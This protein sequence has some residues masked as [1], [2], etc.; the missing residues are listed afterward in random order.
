M[1][2][3][4]IE[5]D[6][7]KGNPPLQLTDLVQQASLHI[8][9]N[10]FA[11][12]LDQL[13]HNI[14]ESGYHDKFRSYVDK[15]AS[16]DQN[17]KFWRQIV[18]KDAL[19]YIGLFL[20]IRSGNWELRLASIKLMA[21]VFTAFDHQTYRKLIAQH[22]AD[23][24]SFPDEVLSTFRQGGFV[25]SLTGRS[26]HSVAL[27]EAHEMKINKECKTSIVHPSRDYINRVAGYIPYR[28]KC[29]E[30][31]RHQ[32]FPVETNATSLAT[33][34][35]STDAQTKKSAANIEAQ[36]QLM[37]STGF[38][39]NLCT[40]HE[41]VN[42]FVMKY[43]TPEQQHDLLHFRNIGQDEFERHVSYYILKEASVHPPMR[44]K[45]L[46]TL[47]QRKVTRRQLSQLE[48]DRQM[49][50][51]CLH[52]KIKWSKQTG[53]PIDKIAEQYIP[54]PLALADSNGIPL[55]GQKSNT[56][57]ALKMRYKDAIPQVFLNTLPEQW[58][59]GC[60][61][62]EGMFM[63]N[64][65]PLGS[66]KTFA[67]YANFLIKRFV[68]PHY[69]K[70]TKDVHMIF[71]NPGRLSQTPKYFERK[72]RDSSATVIVGHMCDDITKSR[73]IPSKWREDIVNCRNCKRNLVLFLSNYCIKNIPK[74]IPP[75]KGLLLAGCFDG[76]LEDTAWFIT[77]DSTPQPNPAFTSNAEETDTRIWLHCKQIDCDKILILSPDTDIYHIGL[78][79]NHGDKDIIIRI[80]AYN[81][82]DLCFLKL[83][84]FI[85]ALKNDPDLSAL[86]PNLLPQILQTLFVATGCDYISFFSGIGKATFLR[87]FFQ[88]SE[89]ITS[90][91]ENITGT[92]ADVGTS[93]ENENEQGFMSFLRLVGVVYMMAVHLL[94]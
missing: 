17:W 48:K 11:P 40:N 50:Q 54:I 34:I 94:E 32:L 44:K 72:R 62:V 13:R 24:H 83:T 39:P 46:Q 49:V 30:N 2:L 55:K 63:L 16:L 86:Q 87:Y 76:H 60:V 12:K 5:T 27:D 10:E 37:L 22:V 85:E 29:M 51:K 93:A 7:E 90:G 61:I 92:L 25:A 35:L 89:F 64:T 28:A 69:A 56:T 65:T 45:R 47:S 77:R 91:Q 14:Q 81:S 43:P 66:H 19:V 79:L 71:D 21:P 1:L 38:L 84:A 36:I 57:K 3:R 67:D 4:F 70:G 53:R 68:Y 74:Q 18:Y 8:K 33:S 15:M 6:T 59:P 58:V 23:I 82:K 42:Q 52:K 73:Y 26:W 9:S 41:L 31:F 75:G 88:H 20:A 80:S 78:P